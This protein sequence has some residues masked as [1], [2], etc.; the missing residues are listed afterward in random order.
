MD[1][2][3]LA[4]GTAANPVG[5]GGL[6]VVTSTGNIAFDDLDVFSTSGTAVSVS[7]PGPA[8][9][10]T[11][12]VVPVAPAGAGTSTILAHNGPALGLTLATI[13]LRLA[14]LD[15]TTTSVAVQLNTVAGQLSA[16][17]GSTIST[18]SGGGGPV[19]GLAGSG[20]TV[21]YAGTDQR[22]R[23]LRR[24]THG[25]NGRHLQL[26][27]TRDAQHRHASAAFILRP[28]AAPSPS[29]ARPTR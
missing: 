25:N 7:G 12:S 4:I 17:S 21:S 2:D 27:R 9:A 18:T 6:A 1:A 20:A 3:T 28:A 22:H 13:D 14:D 24:L 26:H 15:S 23:R 5:Q 19:F 29:P 16:P 11:F 8:T 10:L